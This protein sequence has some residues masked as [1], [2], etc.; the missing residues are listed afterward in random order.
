MY[1]YLK[2]FHTGDFMPKGNLA[3]GDASCCKAPPKAQKQLGCSEGEERVHILLHSDFNATPL[4]TAYGTV[5]FWI[6][7]Y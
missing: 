7:R 2:V 4:R 5:S 1:G 6:C 3:D